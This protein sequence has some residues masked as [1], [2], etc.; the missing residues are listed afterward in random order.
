MEVL[1]DTDN[2]SAEETS[3]D[4]SATIAKQPSPAKGSAKKESVAAKSKRVT[5]GKTGMPGAAP[6]SKSAIAQARR[7][8][9][10]SALELPRQQTSCGRAKGVWGR[11]LIRSSP[12]FFERVGP[13]REL[14]VYDATIFLLGSVSFLLRPPFLHCVGESLPTGARESTTLPG[15]GFPIELVQWI[16]SVTLFYTR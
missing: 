15:Q 12:R 8:R 6:V 3:A 9:R 14:E 1:M 5:A 16:I 13:D 7:A 10:A 2:K 4:E 11:E